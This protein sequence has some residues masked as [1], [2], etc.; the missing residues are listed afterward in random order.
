M[1]LWDK[2]YLI[3]VLP[4]LA[5]EIRD[6]LR[7]GDE[8][9][10]SDQVGTLIVWGRCPCGDDFCSTFY[11]GPRPIARWSDEGEHRTIPLR[12]SNGMIN[13]DVVSGIIREVEVLDRPD[14]K[15]RVASFPTLARS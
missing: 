4:D 7:E 8:T 1:S 6:A 13:L 2:P 3:D 11:T 12:V 5:D 15:E 9:E 14:L 10:L